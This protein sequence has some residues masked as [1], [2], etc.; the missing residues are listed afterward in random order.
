MARAMARGR[1]P[2]THEEHDAFT[3]SLL[4]L[5]DW[6]QRNARAVIVGAVVLALIAA[7]VLYY[8]DYR[9]TVEEQAAV[10]LQALAAS[11]ARMD[12]VEATTE[13]RTFIDRYGDTDATR[14]A[15][16]Y[17]ARM[18]LQLGEAEAA[19]EILEPV[20]GRP[21]DTPLGY[22]AR[23]L[24]AAAYEAAGQPDAALGVLET[25]G[26]RAGYPFQRRR[27]RADRAR[28]LAER[29]RLEEAERIY[30]S[31][32][33]ETEA[34]EGTAEENSLYRVRLAEIRAAIATGGATGAPGD[35]SD[36]PPGAGAG[37][38]PADAP[39]EA[40]T[41]PSSLPGPSEPSDGP[42]NSP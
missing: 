11:V 36:A 24:L 13:L 38:A 27:A 4:R 34:A 22:G 26:E 17:L 21:A 35:A 20:A 6:A 18:R 29:G 9:R 2:E 31:L 33:Q 7:A 42:P 28:L 40:D 8:V 32:V 25:L 14:E 23:V 37:A 30:A 39:A 10:Q 15:R 41:T 12:P 19:I 5:A 3:E 16:L 1:K